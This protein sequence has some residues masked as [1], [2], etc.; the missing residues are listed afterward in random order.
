M[1]SGFDPSLYNMHWEPAP[2]TNSMRLVM[3]VPAEVAE[4]HAEEI[5]AYLNQLVAQSRKQIQ[6]PEER[7]WASS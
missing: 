3:D 5:K 7:W 2:G 1:R 4:K 6:E